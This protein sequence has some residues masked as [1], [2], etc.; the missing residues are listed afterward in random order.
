MAVA[1]AFTSIS[2]PL[3]LQIQH[4][5]SKCPL[6]SLI[7]IRAS[8]NEDS[9]QAQDPAKL[10]LQQLDQQLSVLSQRTTPP[11]RP[12]SGTENEAPVKLKTRA[13]FEITDGFLVFA[14]VGLL[15]LTVVNNL[16][17]YTFIENPQRAAETSKTASVTK[18]E[19]QRS[20]VGNAPE[21]TS[22]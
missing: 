11:P 20:G 13:E 1:F 14:G 18:I 15:L 2:I 19:S 16:L 5:W 9:P 4:P 12:I 8:S 3:K 21:L 22:N 7:R 6:S 17:F 10:A